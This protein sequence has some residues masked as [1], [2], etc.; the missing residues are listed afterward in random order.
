MTDQQ[1]FDTIA[2]LGNG[3]I[4]TPNLDRLVRRGLTFNN[5]YSPCPVCVA[6]RYTIRTGCSSLKTRVFSNGIDAPAPGQ[7]VA[8]TDRCGPYLASEMSSRGYRT[9]GI[10]KF[11]SNPWNEELGYQSHLHSEELYGSP[12]QRRGDAYA[13]FISQHHPSY[14][15][16]EGLMGE[17]TEMYYMPQ[18]SPMPAHCTVE[19]W[20]AARAIE[21]IRCED[22]RP[23]LASYL[24]LVHIHR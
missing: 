6:A 9:F 24:L 5:A 10:G 3:D 15:F 2:A 18:M 21:H 1:R 22:G 11:H 8:M 7:A 12:E 20:V 14:D 13:S 23:F 4:Y 17:R 19:S 16:I